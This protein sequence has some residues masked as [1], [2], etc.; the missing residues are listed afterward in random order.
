MIPPGMQPED[1]PRLH[2]GCSFRMERFHGKPAWVLEDPH[3]GN[4]FRMG[5]A[6]AAFLRLLTGDRSVAALLQDPEPEL[7]APRRAELLARISAAG[8]LQNSQPGLPARRPPKI[9]NLLFTRIP[10]G[11]PDRFLDRVERWIGP[12][13]SPVGALLCG[14]LVLAGLYR[15]SLD[16]PLFLKSLTDVF[17][18]GNAPLLLG[19]FILLKVVHEMGHGIVCHRF[20]GHISEWGVFLIFF[21]PLTYVDAT[22]VWSL[23]SKGQRIAISSAGMV[24]EILT[25]A[26]AALIWSNT[27][28][29]VLRTLCANTIVLATV[30]TLF[31]NANPL[32]R[33]DGYFI[34]SDLIEIPNL[35]QRAARASSGFLAATLL[36]LG[37]GTT[38]PPGMI[39]Y[40]IGCL[41]WRV[42]VIGTICIASVAILHGPGILLALLA[43]AAI[44]VPQFPGMAAQAKSLR[45]SKT[46]WKWWRPLAVG[47]LVGA[48][49]FAPLVPSASAPGVVAFSDADPI[50]VECPGFVEE[51]L[52][53][54]G[55]IVDAGTLLFRLSN[56]SERARV[57]RLQTMARRSEALAL[58]LGNRQQIQLQAQEAARARGL[59]LQAREAEAYTATLD[60]HAPRSGEVIGSRLQD[61]PGAFQRSGSELAILGS[62]SGTEVVAAIPEERISRIPL[63][64][65]QQVDL[66]FPGRNLRLAGKVSNFERSATRQIR[67][68][69]F[70]ASAGGP[71][72]T[73]APEKR[74][75]QR[76]PE[77]L[78][79]PVVYVTIEPDAPPALLG[80][81]PCVVR[82]S[83]SKRTNLWNLIVRNVTRFWDQAARRTHPL[84]NP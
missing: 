84:D 80:G 73:R 36:G 6:E 39:A 7:P 75:G 67:E 27:E 32:M 43:I 49:L 65:G 50:R 35:Y 30:T 54:D 69:A 20:G 60:I 79:E 56:P 37:R 15:I 70:A 25:A 44:L 53:Q 3:S 74:S 48:V 41:V 64:P 45:A 72:A 13:V 81:E 51:V 63:A 78:V 61:L 38:E 29:G 52:V 66:Y 24:A 68:E 5:D 71:L 62:R 46:P 57:A 28:E 23:P 42:L 33:Y 21:F 31:F 34:L 17:S 77:E 40:G 11:N 26:I 83:G 9:P 12:L 14:L 22:S 8:L 10:L 18:V 82:F 47:L 19:I 58:E 76:D 16:L 55:E 4:F 2:P 59:A 1:Q